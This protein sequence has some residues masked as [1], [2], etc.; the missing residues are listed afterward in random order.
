MSTWMLVQNK[1]WNGR[2]VLNYF[3]SAAGRSLLRWAWHV[4]TFLISHNRKGKILNFCH[5]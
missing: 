3:L 1:F 2:N 4:Q 5:R